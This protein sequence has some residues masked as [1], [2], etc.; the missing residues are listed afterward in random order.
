MKE[1]FEK[2]TVNLD[3]AKKIRNAH[4][5]QVQTMLKQQQE[6]LEALMSH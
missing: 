3:E 2:W 5:Q 4:Q 6:Q 1:D